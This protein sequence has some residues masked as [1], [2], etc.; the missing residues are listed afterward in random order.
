MKIEIK[1]ETTWKGFYYWT[2][3]DNAFD[4]CFLDLDA[5]EKRL[6]EL[7]ETTKQPPVVEVIKSIEI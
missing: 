3:V 6:V 2:Y 7:V 4:H 1:K 5:A